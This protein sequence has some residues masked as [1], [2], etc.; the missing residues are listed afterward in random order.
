M[1]SE[2]NEP[3]RYAIE[4]KPDT[5]T[6]RSQAEAEL[7]ADSA[8]LNISVEGSAAFSGAEAFTKAKEVQALVSALRTVGIEERQIKLRS[9]NLDSQS[10]SLIKSS[11]AS[12]R[13]K[14]AHVSMD[15]LAKVLGAI[16]TQKSCTLNHL[17][18]NYS[19]AEA[20]KQ[21]LRSEALTKAIELAQQDAEIL[22]VQILGIY[23]L[24]ELGRSDIVR[25]YVSTEGLS[26]MKRS[27]QA[28]VDLGFTLGNSTTI[29]VELEA[30][31]RVSSIAV[32]S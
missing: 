8:D 3:E 32:E 29:A 27:R 11:S 21:R 18:W 6:V 30:E 17:N 4:M 14:I 26:S 13:L 7:D 19:T 23:S 9:V 15:A 10:F 31:F 20:V 12:Y 1:F 5:I 28:A 25:E 16:A 2:E 24:D 22:G